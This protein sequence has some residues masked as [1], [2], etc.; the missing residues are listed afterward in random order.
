LVHGELQIGPLPQSILLRREWAKQG[1]FAF[2]CH[3]PPEGVEGILLQVESED[4]IAGMLLNRKI[5]K[6]EKWN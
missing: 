6:V 2:T 1:P 4:E 5:N 3:P